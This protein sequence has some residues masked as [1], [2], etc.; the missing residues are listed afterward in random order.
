MIGGT[1]NLTESEDDFQPTTLNCRY[2]TTF[3]AGEKG[4]FREM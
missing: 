3:Q 2:Y 1:V 4:N